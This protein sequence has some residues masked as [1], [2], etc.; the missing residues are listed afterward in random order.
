M[1]SFGKNFPDKLFETNLR[2]GGPFGNLDKSSIA[3]IDG[4]GR[5]A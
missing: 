4:G 2:V 5:S 3:G 1:P